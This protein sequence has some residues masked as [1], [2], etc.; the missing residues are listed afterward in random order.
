MSD[1]GTAI[2]YVLKQE[3]G[4]S[5]R[6]NDKG[7]ITGFGISLRFIRSLPIDRLRDYHIFE[8]PTEQTIKD[9]TI[10][11]AKKIYYGEFWIHAPFDKIGNQDICNYLF[12]MAINMGISPAIKC[13]Q[14]ACW[15]VMQRWELLHDDGILGDKTIS[16]IQQ[17]GYLYK[18]ALRAERANYYRALVIADPSQ[19]EFLNGWFNRTYNS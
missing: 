15:A 12:D 2:N 9:L 11:Q 18:S 19:K 14:R 1:F 17:C 7:G 5:E 3:G 13:A 10:E 4:L 8:E 6:S 16:T